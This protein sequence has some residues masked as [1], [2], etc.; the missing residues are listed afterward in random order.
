[1]RRRWRR[2]VMLVVV[3][4]TG[5]AIVFAVT[6]AFTYV[7]TSG[8]SMEPAF[9]AGD[10]AI[11]RRAPRYEVGDVV[12]FRS[13]ELQTVVLHRIVDRTGDRFVTRGDNN[14]FLDPEEPTADEIIG[15]LWLRVPAGGRAMDW[16][17]QPWNA[18]GLALV[19]LLGAGGLG[20]RRRRR[21][22]RSYRLGSG[23]RARRRDGP[24]RP[25]RDRRPVGPALAQGLAL[26]GA[27]LL[28]LGAFALVRP[29]HDVSTEAVAY[30]HMVTV[31]YDAPVD[32]AAVYPDGVRPGAPVYRRLA[33]RLEIE[34]RY[35]VQPGHDVQVAGELTLQATL[36]SGA[37][38]ERV[39]PTLDVA[40]ITGMEARASG[41]IRLPDLDRV[42]L[43]MTELTGVPPGEIRLVVEAV[44]D[45]EG[46]VHGQPVA[47]VVSTVTTFVV[48]QLQLRPVEEPATT[49]EKRHVER[50]VTTPAQVE[51][52]GV[53]AQVRLLRWVG[54]LGGA[55][56]LLA[57]LAAWWFGPRTVRREVDRILMRHRSLVVPVVAASVPGDAVVELASFDAL[58]R[59]ARHHDLLVLHAV[60]PSDVG[61]ADDEFIL[62]VGG[63]TYRYSTVSRPAGPGEGNGW[64]AASDNAR[65]RADRGPQPAVSGADHGVVRSSRRD[66]G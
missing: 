3:A 10:L 30:T 50:T 28:A 38:W 37:G 54:L 15:R 35:E 20:V 52:L 36:R 6:G 1:M 34:A 33:D 31:G 55:A 58:V 24:A 17:R 14:D 4:A 5:L 62:H 57:A 51:V 47:D 7:Q 44:A 8:N 60:G 49:T 46:Q 29:E 22:Q 2:W 41:R 21:R 16:L 64:E 59:L 63:V 45:V 9:R 48:D 23:T 42:V 11:V 26:G 19:A 25:A 32:A 43:R 40:G 13:A 12:A 56:L 18:G 27:A 53:G 39:L 61:S 65:T 66:D